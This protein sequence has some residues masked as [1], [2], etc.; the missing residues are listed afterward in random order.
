MFKWWRDRRRRKLAEE[1]FPD[2]WLQIIH[3]NCRHFATLDQAERARLLRDVR[4]FLEEKSIEVSLGLVLTDEMRVTVAVHASLLGLG[5]NA[6]PFD[7]LISVILQPDIYV[8]TKVQREPS[9]LELHSQ[10]ERLGEAWRNGPVLLSWRD[11]ARQ[12][13]EEPD[14]RNVI[15]HEFAHLLDMADADADGIPLLDTEEQFRTWLD[16]TR[17]EYRRLVRH[18]EH[19]RRT[20][21]DWY[22]S[23]NEAEFFAVA[24]ETF[25]EQPVE[26]QNLHPSLYDVLRAFYKQDPAAR[27]LRRVG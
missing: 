13:R 10:E 26:M 3:G 4:W 18:A 2:E 27:W 24:T 16:V 9:G 23:T 12:C 7:R 22:G 21:L 15:L 8:A 17:I 5:F 20:L 1:P 19:G 14:G 6:P 25:F 11:V